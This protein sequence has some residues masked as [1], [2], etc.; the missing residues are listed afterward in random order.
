MNSYFNKL[1]SIQT[2]ALV[3]YLALAFTVNM[4]YRLYFTGKCATLMSGIS[5]ILARIVELCTDI[6]EMLIT[7]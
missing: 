6:S 3:E 7:V 1:F 5:G 4:S 2:D